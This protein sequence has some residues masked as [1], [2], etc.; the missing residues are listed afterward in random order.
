MTIQRSTGSQDM[1]DNGS[2]EL[3][4]AQHAM[5]LS[6]IESVLSDARTATGLRSI[7]PDAYDAVDRF[8]GAVYRSPHLSPRMKELVLLA[9]HGSS[10]SLNAQAIDRHVKRALRAGASGADVH[11]VLVTIIPLANHPL[12]V[13]IPV[14]LDELNKAGQESGAEPTSLT[15][16]VQAI[17]D[18]FISKRGYWTPMRDTIGRL[19]PEYFKSFIHACMEPWRSGSLTP[20]ER[21]LLYIAIDCSVTHT[22]EPGMRMHIQNALRYQATR[23]EILEVFQLAGLMGIEGYILAADCLSKTAAVSTPRHP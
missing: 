3:E 21:E 22:Y 1:S 2:N 9:L 12:Y 19:M 13:G 15:A 18:D 4:P 16:D 17:R 7:A 14:L 6:R 5:D 8:W 20:K 11:D 23:D 10:S